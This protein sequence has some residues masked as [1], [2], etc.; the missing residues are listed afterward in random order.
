MFDLF[1]V[2]QKM[3]KKSTDDDPRNAEFKPEQDLF[4]G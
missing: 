3:Q 2:P 4:A 1:F